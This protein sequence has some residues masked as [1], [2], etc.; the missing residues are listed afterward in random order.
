MQYT[1]ASIVFVTHFDIVE[2]N[3]RPQPGF[4]PADIDDLRNTGEKE[5]V[6]CNKLRS[7]RNDRYDAGDVFEFILILWKLLHI[8]LIFSQGSDWPHV[9]KTQAI[10]STYDGL[11]DWH[12]IY[13]TQP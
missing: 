6:A 10:V 1:Q 5:S 12:I 8:L 13:V 11:V 2:N 9:S 4:L 7:R 3:V